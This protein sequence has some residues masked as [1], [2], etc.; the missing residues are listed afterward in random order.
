MKRVQGRYIY[1][2]HFGSVRE[3]TRRHGFRTKVGQ[4]KGVTVVSLTS[5]FRLIQWRDGFEKV[6]NV[7]DEEFDGSPISGLES[8]SGSSLWYQTL[9]GRSSQ[10]RNTWEFCV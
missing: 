1:H 9:D 5:S 4:T 10:T 8:F 7:G 6:P 3:E 2:G